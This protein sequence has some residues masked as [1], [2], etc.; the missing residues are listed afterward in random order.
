MRDSLVDISKFSKIYGEQGRSKVQNLEEQT[1]IMV[2]L[3]WKVG[4]M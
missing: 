2:E 1:A 4:H 3:Q